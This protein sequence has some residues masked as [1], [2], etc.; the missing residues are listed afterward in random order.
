M[1]N[2][3][4]VFLIYKETVIANNTQKGFDFMKH[5]KTISLLLALVI[6]IGSFNFVI[7]SGSN[8]IDNDREGDTQKFGPENW[9]RPYDTNMGLDANGK[10]IYGTKNGKFGNSYTYQ[11]W[12]AIMMNWAGAIYQPH[13]YG[14]G[15]E[16]GI[17]VDKT[18]GQEIFREPKI[19][20]DVIVIDA[21]TT[22]Q[23]IQALDLKLNRFI[24]RY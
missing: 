5:K 9:T 10:N 13:L 20:Y 21:D 1:N 14:S 15:G 2:L 11:Q 24:R 18:T 16:A 17:A 12:A 6:L 4:K 7:A 19:E 22:P 23:S 8:K 3:I